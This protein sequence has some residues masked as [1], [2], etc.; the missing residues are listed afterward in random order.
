MKKNFTD[1]STQLEKAWNL[2]TEVE[3]EAFYELMDS[4]E[5]NEPIE[6]LNKLFDTIRLEDDFGVYESLYNAIWSF[7]PATVTQTLAGR[8][9]ELQQRLGHTYQVS[10]FCIPVSA[11]EIPLNAF[12]DAASQWTPSEKEIVISAITEWSVF[13]EAWEILL[14][15]L[16]KPVIKTEEDPIPEA[17][18]ESWKKRLEHARQQEGEFS[19]SSMFWKKGKKEWL[20]DLDF[21]FEVLALD[22]G[23]N[24]RQVDTMT[25]PL[26]FFAKTTVYPVFIE[27]LKQL[28]EEKK[29]KILDNI[30][31]SNKGK[32]TQLA[33]A[34]S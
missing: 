14:E 7:P 5:G 11:N 34:I 13:D 12:I 15:K 1:W 17:W 22:H 32:Y 20:E 28:P 3:C 18:D 21:L 24:W 33:A 2:E 8:L 23:K 19:I 27:K 16:G 25:N 31:R 30:R 29:K 6:Y 26:W 9:P 10:R 4:I